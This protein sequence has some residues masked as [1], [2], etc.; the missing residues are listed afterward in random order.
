MRIDD[1]LL[2]RVV[3][4]LR[5]LDVAARTDAGLLAR[6]RLTE[7]GSKGIALGTVG[8]KLIGRRQDREIGLRHSQ[9]QVLLRAAEGRLRG[10][11]LKIRFLELAEGLEAP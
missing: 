9:Q 11:G 7:Q 5:L 4:T 6:S 3:E 8:G 1:A 10:G 2:G